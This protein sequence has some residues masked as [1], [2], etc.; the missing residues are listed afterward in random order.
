MELLP[1]QQRVVDERNGLAERLTRLVA[2][3][4]TPPFDALSE[5]EMGL[6]EAQ[7][8]IMLQYVQVLTRRIRNFNEGSTS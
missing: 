1:Y 6:L 5:A 3:F 4:S 8:T 7:A 2:F